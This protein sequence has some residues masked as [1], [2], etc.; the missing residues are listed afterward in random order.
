MDAKDTG[1]AFEVQVGRG[2]NGDK[3]TLFILWIYSAKIN[4]PGIVKTTLNIPSLNL[5][6]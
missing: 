2:N 5:K 3:Y 1:N 4:R 6:L